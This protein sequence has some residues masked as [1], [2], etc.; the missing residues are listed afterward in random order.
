MDETLISA[1]MVGMA[2][3]AKDAQDT[4]STSEKPVNK[5]TLLTYLVWGIERMSKVAQELLTPHGERGKE[6]IN[7]MYG[8]IG[9]VVEQVSL[10]CDPDIGI[11]TKYDIHDINNAITGLSGQHQMY[12]L[13]KRKL[14]QDDLHNVLACAEILR[15]VI[16][17]R[18]YSSN[19]VACVR[20]FEDIIS[21]ALKGACSSRGLSEQNIRF[22]R[23]RCEESRVVVSQNA[24]IYTRVMLNAIIN[25]I[26]ALGESI[27]DPYVWI[28][29]YEEDGQVTIDVI[30]NGVGISADTLPHVFDCGFST[31]GRCG[32]GIGLAYCKK[33]I[34][35]VCGGTITISSRGAGLGTDV[36]IQIPLK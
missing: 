4:S 12:K 19:D 30:D 26:D 18:M 36:C 9:K 6:K 29:V 10:L 2:C 17:V 27:T 14:S 20:N 3:S 33:A 1:R 5:I 11:F 22:Q 34:E 32:S 15:Q 31:K 16:V 35:N 13:C 28:N 7:E 25:S 23:D 8:I 24:G 21:S